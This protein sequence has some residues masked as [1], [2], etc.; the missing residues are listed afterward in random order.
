MSVEKLELPDPVLWPSGF[1]GRQKVCLR[2]TLI[3]SQATMSS[4]FVWHAAGSMGAL[5]RCPRI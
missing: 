3:P 2:M 4:G 1:S 5:S